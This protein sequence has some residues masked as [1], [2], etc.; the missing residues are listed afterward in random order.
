LSTWRFGSPAALSD[1]AQRCDQ[2]ALAPTKRAGL[3]ACGPR[4]VSCPPAPA[5]IATCTP[6]PRPAER[7]RAPTEASP[8]RAS[9]GRLVTR[10][11]KGQPPAV[12]VTVRST[13]TV[14]RHRSRPRPTPTATPFLNRVSQ[15]RTGSSPRRA[16]ARNAWTS[17]GARGCERRVM[18]LAGLSLWPAS[19][20]TTAMPHRS[21]ASLPIDGGLLV[22]QG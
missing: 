9:R 7:D 17:L 12:E 4:R 14:N 22:G 20:P 2:A 10:T 6:S 19:S 5:C 15:P 8:H 13:A 16:T 21:A 18:T 1:T 11:P 3:S